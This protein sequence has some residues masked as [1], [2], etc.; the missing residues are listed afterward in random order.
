MP[1]KYPDFSY[2][3]TKLPAIVD[4]YRRSLESNE[5]S[6]TFQEIYDF[7]FYIPN[8]KR[9]VSDRLK[10]ILRI[11]RSKGAVDFNDNFV[12]IRL[13]GI[14]LCLLTMDPEMTREEL[15]SRS[16]NPNES[17]YKKMYYDS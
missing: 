5:V 14:K 4:L 13:D 3:N 17:Y 16:R 11:L 15:T 10:D 6:L 7:C 12:N 2:A 1:S 8:Y 9:E